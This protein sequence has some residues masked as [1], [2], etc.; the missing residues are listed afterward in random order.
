MFFLKS[1]M[2]ILKSSESRF[3]LLGVSEYI[4]VFMTLSRQG[5]DMPCLHRKL[6][7]RILNNGHYGCKYRFFLSR[8]PK[9]EPKRPRHNEF[10]VRGHQKIIRH[11]GEIIYGYARGTVCFKIFL[12]LFF[13][14]FFIFLFYISAQVFI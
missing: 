1:I 13:F 8:L 3:R 2:S 9:T 14:P 11:A 7:C 6:S 5:L 4:Y 12:A 10:P